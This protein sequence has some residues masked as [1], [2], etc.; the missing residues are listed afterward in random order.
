MLRV[1]IFITI[2][3]FLLALINVICKDIIEVTGVKGW[4]EIK[5]ITREEAKERAIIEAQKEALRKAKIPEQIS[6]SGILLTNQDNKNYL[7]IFEEV[8]TVEINGAI[9]EY[10]IV[11]ENEIIDEFKNMISEVE[12]NAK[13]I[14]YESKKDPSFDFRV[15][16]I[17]KLYQDGDAL[18]FSITP[19]QNGYLKIFNFNDSNCILLYPFQNNIDTNLNDE[20]EHLFLKNQLCNFPVKEF[21]G[22]KKNETGFTMEALTEDENNYIVIVFTKQN[23]PFI[24][25][26]TVNNLLKWIYSI[27]PDQRAV[28]YFQ[29]I[30]KT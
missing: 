18:N 9:L 17:K 7:Q 22:N 21:I 23:L 11:T 16:G 27:P 12:I 8:S 24:E 4:C 5:N 29:F 19:A 15:E 26:A 28:K 13:V 30:I 10:H 2:L 1:R 14:K 6:V 3:F 20:I 25:N